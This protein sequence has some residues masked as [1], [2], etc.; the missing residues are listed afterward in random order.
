[1]VRPRPVLQPRPPWEWRETWSKGAPRVCLSNYTDYV[2]IQ[3]G[4][5]KLR[6][7]RFDWMLRLYQHHGATVQSVLQDVDGERCVVYDWAEWE[8]LKPLAC[9]AEYIDAAR[10]RVY[11]ISF[12]DI[13]RKGRR[14]TTRHGDAWVVPLHHYTLH[15]TE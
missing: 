15:E 9:W 6:T 3:R 2:Y 7:G 12:G 10:E 8:W 4:G 13:C 5:T 1:M 14:T 11:R